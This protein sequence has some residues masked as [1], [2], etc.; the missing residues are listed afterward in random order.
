LN[1]LASQVP[2]WSLVGQFL[3]KVGA[4]VGFMVGGNVNVPD[5]Y[6]CMELAN[7]VA[8][9]LGNVVGSLQGAS[10]AAGDLND[11]IKKRKK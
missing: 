6:K 4:A 2:T 5:P 1:Q 7:T 10:D 8:S 11:L 9:D 3:I